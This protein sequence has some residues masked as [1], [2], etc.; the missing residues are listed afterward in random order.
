MGSFF[1]ITPFRVVKS[2][3]PTTAHICPW[4]LQMSPVY[5]SI[6]NRIWLKAHQKQ[7]ITKTYGDCEQARQEMNKAWIAEMQRR[8]R[9]QVE[10]WEAKPVKTP[11]GCRKIKSRR[12][13]DY[14]EVD[15]YNVVSRPLDDDRFALYEG[16]KRRSHREARMALD[17]NGE[18]ESWSL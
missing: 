12:Y 3:S 13:T 16:A 8:L 11:G 9:D 14:E 18:I 17:K 1:V 6:K 10:A 7:V 4:L 2:T 5:K 15:D